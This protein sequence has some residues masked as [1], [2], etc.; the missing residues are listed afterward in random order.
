MIDKRAVFIVLMILV[1][2]FAYGEIKIDKEAFVD[3]VI[4]EIDNSAIFNLKI[5]NLGESD[6]FR[7]YSLVG[8]VISPAENFSI[9]SGDTKDVQINIKL[10]PA[11]LANPQTFSF[12]YKV[13]G[14]KTGITEDSMIIKVISLKNALNINSYNINLE[15]QEAKIYVKSNVGIKFDSIKARFSSAFFDFSEE[16]PLDKYQT[17]EFSVPLNNEEIKT[18]VAGEYTITSDIET[19]NVKERIENKFRFTEK[20]EISTQESVSGIIIRKRVIEKK[21]EGNLPV[22]VQIEIK[23][24]I[25]SRLF[26]TYNIEP[27]YVS[28]KNFF[29]DFSFQKEVRPAETFVVRANTNWLYPLVIVILIVIIA[30]L[31]RIYVSSNLVVK[32][33]TAFLKTKTGDFALKISISVRAKKFVENIN[34]ID[35]LPSMVKLYERFGAVEPNR[36]DEKNRRIE[37]DISSLNP[38]EE[39]IFSYIIYSKIAPVGKYELPTA[40]AIYE[41]DNKTHESESNKVFFMSESRKSFSN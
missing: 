31:V 3:S 8:P 21:N 22:V 4:P 17:A 30:C 34:L 28:R 5:T 40:T 35:R 1:I 9:A 37:W 29:V 6:I 13:E 12:V 14:Q 19:A 39:R 27:S 11:I 38:G 10:S 25:I 7:V 24:D 20:S 23:K 26:T 41:R 18:L 33:K 2:P 32:K 15:S 16:F 36:I